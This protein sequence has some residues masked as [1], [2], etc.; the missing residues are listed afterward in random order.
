MYLFTVNLGIKTD[1]LKCSSVFT[2]LLIALL[3]VANVISN[4]KSRYPENMQNLKFNG[5][6]YGYLQ[7]FC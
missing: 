6:D 3:E 4:R 7:V 1:K 5:Q 2:V